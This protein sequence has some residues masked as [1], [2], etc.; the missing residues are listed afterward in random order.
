MKIMSVPQDHYESH[1]FSKNFLPRFFFQKIL[2]IGSTKQEFLLREFYKKELTGF[3]SKLFS[4]KISIVY[5]SNYATQHAGTLVFQKIIFGKRMSVRLILFYFG[6]LHGKK[7]L[8]VPATGSPL[9]S[10]LFY[11]SDFNEIEIKIRIF[12]LNVSFDLIIIPS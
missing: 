8:L 3:E 7:V 4:K 6:I 11:G 1:F 10:T 5:L 9:K 12:L 2:V